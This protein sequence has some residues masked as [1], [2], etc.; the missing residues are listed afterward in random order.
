M[1]GLW[2]S[3]GP[4]AWYLGPLADHY[5]CNLYYVPETRAYHISGP[6]KLF[7]Q[8]C[9]IPN[10]SPNAHLKALTKELQTA[11]VKAAGTPKGNRLI[12]SLATVINAILPPANTEEQRVATN[13]VIGRPLS[14]DTPI[15]M[16]QRILD[17]PEI[18]QKRDPSAKCNLITTACIHQRQTQNNT[19]G[20]LPK[21]SPAKPALIQ[22]EPD[23][24][25]EATINQDTQHHITRDHHPTCANTRR[26]TCKCTVS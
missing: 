1:Q 14:E 13:I 26:S 2:A 7:L 9:Q 22:P 18:M 23:N 8:H 17:A 19:P 20:A 3:W 12:K 16:I 10:L 4:G 6:A 5:W 21:F 15:V 25:G 11:T 24:H